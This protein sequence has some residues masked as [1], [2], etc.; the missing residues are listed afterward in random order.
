MTITLSPQ[1]I[2]QL[3]RILLS[4]TL[5][6]CV[7]MIFNEVVVNLIGVIEEGL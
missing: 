1:L 2:N 5:K 3:R 4:E 7:S 6:S